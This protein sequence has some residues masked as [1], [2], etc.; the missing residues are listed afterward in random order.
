MS[1]GMGEEPMGSK[2]SIAL[3]FTSTSVAALDEDAV[4][5]VS[6]AV[7]TDCD[8]FGHRECVRFIL[9]PDENPQL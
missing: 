9:G 7:V 6:V 3:R 8:A 1:V 4:E 2:M 5:H